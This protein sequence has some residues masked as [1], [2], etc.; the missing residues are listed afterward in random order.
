[1]TIQ[2]AC[3]QIASVI[4]TVPGIRQVHDYAPDNP[5]AFPAAIIYPGSGAF[6]NYTIGNQRS[7]SDI[8]IDVLEPMQQQQLARFM[9]TFTAFVDT[10]PAALLA[11]MAGSGSRFGNTLET[12]ERIDYTFLPRIE[13]AADPMRGYRFIIRGVK[14]LT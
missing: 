10:I 1:M 2:A 9:D 14:I 8:T 12:F 7:L 3:L 11:Q 6:Q 13:Y 4:R 5:N